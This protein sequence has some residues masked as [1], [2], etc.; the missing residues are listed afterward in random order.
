MFR[1]R[2]T[3]VRKHSQGLRSASRGWLAGLLALCVWFRCAADAQ[4]DGPPPAPEPSSPHVEAPGPLLGFDVFVD[5]EAIHL[6]L[7]VPGDAPESAQAVHRVSRDGGRTWSAPV[8]VDQGA[9]VPLRVKHGSEPQLAFR[10]ETGVAAWTAI[11]T[12]FMKR[13][14]ATAAWTTDGGRT[15]KPGPPPC[16]TGTRNSQ[17]FLDL[18]VDAGGRFHL[19]WLDGRTDPRTSY[20]ASS[21]GPDAGWSS[22]SVIDGAACACCWNRLTVGGDGSVYLAYRDDVPR[23]MGVAVW[24]PAGAAWRSLGRAG[25]F[26]WRVDGCPHVGGGIVESLGPRGCTL[27]AVVWTARE[28]AVGLYLVSC[29]PD[30]GVWTAPVRIGSKTAKHADLAFA[31]GRLVCAWDAWMAPDDPS[32]VFV[33]ESADGGATWS[34]PM[35]LSPP[36]IAS[37]F[38]RVV[39]VGGRRLVFFARE[40]P[41]GA[42]LEGPVDS[43]LAGSGKRE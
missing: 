27:H 5:G 13:G 37:S 19:V 29:A 43:A 1:L 17:A 34:E 32:A 26:D 30:R 7:E 40:D 25:A 31:G 36:G 24:E 9:D 20:S 28:D 12:G 35:R 39:R 15:W 10:G 14:P 23:D 8:R 6:L 42:R 41:G 2:R 38:P 4:A 22:P 11:G 33:A 18:A 16:P 21:T 3:I